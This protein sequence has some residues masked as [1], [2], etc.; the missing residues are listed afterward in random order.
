MLK[1][2]ICTLFRLDLHFVNLLGWHF[3]R[4]P[5]IEFSSA[6]S[7]AT[8]QSAGRCWRHNGGDKVCDHSTRTIT[9]H[10]R[11]QIGQSVVFP[12][13]QP[14]QSWWHSSFIHLMG[15]GLADEYLSVQINVAIFT[16]KH[17][18]R[19]CVCVCVR[20]IW[21]A[22]LHNIITA[23]SKA[24]RRLNTL[25][26]GAETKQGRQSCGAA[27]EPTLQIKLTGDRLISTLLVTRAAFQHVYRQYRQGCQEAVFS[28]A[29]QMECIFKVL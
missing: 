29:K 21:M 17:K 19:A 1:M 22:M 12:L 20:S 13:R 23:Y 5:H 6:D 15:E 10:T 9:L 11:P 2:G 16:R 24:A 8:Q 27:D 26:L 4:W 28:N 3:S 14:E 7:A 18:V 25:Q